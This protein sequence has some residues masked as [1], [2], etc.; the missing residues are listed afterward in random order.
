[1]SPEDEIAPESVESA[2]SFESK[3]IQDKKPPVVLA[4]KKKTKSIKKKQMPKPKETP[5]AEEA[6]ETVAPQTQ[7]NKIE[8]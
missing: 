3:Q 1:M 7:D 5:Q 2:D 8:S 4:S 6:S